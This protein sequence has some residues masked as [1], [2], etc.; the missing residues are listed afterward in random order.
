M[1]T[2]AITGAASG[3]GRATA[4][5]LKREGHRTIGVDLRPA[6]TTECFTADLSTP[7]GRR[8]AIDGILERC[9]GRLDGLVPCAGLSGLPDRPGSLLVSLNYFGSIELIDGLHDALAAPG[10]SSVVALCSNSTTTAPNPPLQLVEALA[11]GDEPAARA[12]GDE[13]GSIAAYPATKLALARWLRARSVKEEWIGRGINLNAV[14]PGKT[15][16]AMVAEGMADPI[17]GQ[18]MDKFP[19]PIGRNGQ[20]EEI[21]ELICFLLSEKARFIVGSIFFVDGGTDALLRTNDFPAP[22]ILSR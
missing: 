16:T 18:H 12:V 3:I 8:A 4:A 5:Q 13:T 7:E 22:W 21:A 14:A 1:K 19:M 11:A 9:D 6:D 17:L 10:Q 15:E 2:F 20:P